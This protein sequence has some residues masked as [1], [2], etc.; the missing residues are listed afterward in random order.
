MF[1]LLAETERRR[2]L[3]LEQP[4]RR[5]QF[6]LARAALRRLL[7]EHLVLPADQIAIEIEDNGRPRLHP[8]HGS[9]LQF[10]IAHTTGLVAV[11]IQQ[12]GPIGVDVEWPEH[13]RNHLAL[14]RRFF[15]AKELDF[16]EQ[17]SSDAERAR[18]FMQCW[19]LKEAWYKAF[20][21]SSSWVLAE[22]GFE[23]D[24]QIAQV[25]ATQAVRGVAQGSPRLWLARWQVH[26]VGLCWFARGAA[27]GVECC[28]WQPDFERPRPLALTVDYASAP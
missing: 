15:G 10:S 20:G 22:L 28:L 4:R 16:V 9:D 24:P 26:V 27:V 12:G 23:F 11:A 18:R 6:V 7:A 13:K 8:R 25:A 14:A 19:S 3:E 2:A 1:A 21:G 5:R 17:A